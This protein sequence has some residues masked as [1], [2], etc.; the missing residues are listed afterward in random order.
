MTHE[1][2]IPESYRA[3]KDAK[4][5]IGVVT[6]INYTIDD[7]SID[8][9]I[10]EETYDEVPVFYHCQ[11][12]EDVVNGVYAFSPTDRVMVLHSLPDEVTGAVSEPH[13][14]GFGDGELRFCSSPLIACGYLDPS[15]IH[16]TTGQ[17]VVYYNQK[18]DVL[19]NP[20]LFCREIE[21]AG[22]LGNASFFQVKYTPYTVPYE[23]VEIINEEEV[24]TAAERDV[25][26][27]LAIAK[28]FLFDQDEPHY[29]VQQTNAIRISCTTASETFKIFSWTHNEPIELDPTI[30]KHNASFSANFNEDF[31]KLYVVFHVDDD[32]MADPGESI[33]YYTIYERSVGDNFE[34]LDWTQLDSG[35]YEYTRDIKHLYVDREGIVWGL[36]T[37]LENNNFEYYKFDITDGVLLETDR[38]SVGYTVAD[39]EFAGIFEHYEETPDSEC[40]AIVDFTPSPS[41]D[42]RLYDDPPNCTLSI[43]GSTAN[44]SLAYKEYF[45]SA[46][47]EQTVYVGSEEYV[48][49]TLEGAS[50]ILDNTAS[51]STYTVSYSQHFTVGDFTS[52][53]TCENGVLS[54]YTNGKLLEYTNSYQVTYDDP[55][56]ATER[57]SLLAMVGD[58]GFGAFYDEFYSITCDSAWAPYLSRCIID[59]EKD[60]MFYP[61][62]AESS[63]KM[64]AS[65]IAWDNNEGGIVIY[66]MKYLDLSD[67]WHL[68]IEIA[69][70]ETPDISHDVEDALLTCTGFNVANFHYIGFMF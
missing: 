59:D 11:R 28:G 66:G 22:P 70:N 38:V 12:S 61:F 55:L 50:Y 40:Y 29:P 33:V 10:G 32:P 31:T 44:S 35:S 48:A 63:T 23:R 36:Y 6:D 53:T 67:V 17:S 43:T 25:V 1:I 51:C 54:K 46:Y 14:I 49:E 56:D 15:Y 34:T 27:C 16:Q 62:E 30:P 52:R 26:F 68:I 24:R 18:F 57:G 65:F 42:I 60:E 7:Q 13:I 58:L 8:L 3:E 5:S 47:G 45:S 2:L 39:G 4:L 64:Q 21:P 20:F 9:T 19:N 69:S 41:S 37:E